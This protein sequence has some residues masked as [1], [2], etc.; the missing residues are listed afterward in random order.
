MARMTVSRRLRKTYPGVFSDEDLTKRVES[1]V[2]KVFELLPGDDH[3]VVPCL[4][5]V[6]R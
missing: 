6:A 2:F 5:V 4:D 3:E 1:A